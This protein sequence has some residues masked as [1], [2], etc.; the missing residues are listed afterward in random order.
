LMEEL[1]KEEI[2]KPRYLAGRRNFKEH[3]LR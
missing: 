1:K 3:I 2:K